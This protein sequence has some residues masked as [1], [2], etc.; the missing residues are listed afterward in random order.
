M[1]IVNLQQSAFEQQLPESGNH[2]QA[3]ST[4]SKHSYH[5]N[6][7]KAF[8]QMYDL[9]ED[10]RCSADQADKPTRELRK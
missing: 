10:G 9:L 6:S 1:Q 8:L 5:G 3:L 4:A 7:D 2:P